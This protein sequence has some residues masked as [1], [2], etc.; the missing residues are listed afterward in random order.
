[1]H[2]ADSKIAFMIA[3]EVPCQPI[4]DVLIF[5]ECGQSG[6]ACKEQTGNRAGK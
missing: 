3:V 2:G 4:P 1:V 6:Q 5:R